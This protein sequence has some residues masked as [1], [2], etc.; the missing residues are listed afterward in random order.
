SIGALLRER[1]AAARQRAVRAKEALDK[2]TAAV[3]KA[4]TST[5]QLA[6]RTSAAQVETD[7]RFARL[8]EQIR[9][10]QDSRDSQDCEG[11]QCGDKQMAQV[12]PPPLRGKSPEIDAIEKKLAELAAAQSA[13][14]SVA[15][16]AAASVRSFSFAPERK[17]ARMLVG[18]FLKAMLDE[19]FLAMKDSLPATIR[20][21]CQAWTRSMQTAYVAKFDTEQ[22]ANS[23][24][25]QFRAS[26]PLVA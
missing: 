3:A 21:R 15:A 13:A 9:V 23:F 4:Q 5:N 6:L 17:R 19:R 18:K 12:G 24:Y 8:G 25:D 7:A 26:P 14:A 20:Q 1:G 10:L 2:L 22:D 11:D 16:S